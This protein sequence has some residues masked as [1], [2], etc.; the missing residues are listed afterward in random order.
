LR[1]IV[2][3]A[4][5]FI[6]FH[7]TERLLSQ[8]HE[9]LGI[10]NVNDYYD[11]NLKRNRLKVL[12]DFERFSFEEFDL[13]D[14]DRTRTTFNS[15]QPRYAFHLAAQAGV[16][17]SKQNPQSY[18][19]S[20]ITG[21]LSVLEACRNSRVRDL[22]YASSSSVYGSNKKIPF[23]ESDPVD[24]PTNI[25]AATK[26]ANELMA[27]AYHNLYQINSVGLRFFTVYGPWGRPDMAYY[28]FT[29]RI[30]AGTEITVF[31]N[32]EMSRDFTFIDDIVDGIT[33]LA[34]RKIGLKNYC[35]FVNLGNNK[36]EKLMTFVSE[37]E[38]AIGKKAK[39][40]FK[41]AQAEEM[42]D[43]WADID[44]ASR[45]FNYAPRVSLRQGIEN[46]V[47]WHNSYSKSKKLAG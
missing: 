13:R 43:T 20:N 36:P 23:A 30:K 38:R 3:G 41:P 33:A 19:D 35:D 42:V 24:H 27:E 8:G 17:Y 9:V 21:F 25:Y 46:F 15:F 34:K 1:L 29:E 40:K 18:V 26:R 12:K 22:F 10:D 5:G 14:A 31:N 37:L 11:T 28:F 32:G 6:G 4:A 45:E 7:L 2:T 44:K 39:I 47:D 16:R